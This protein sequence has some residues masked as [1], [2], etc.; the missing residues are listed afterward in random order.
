[1]TALTHTHTHTQTQVFFNDQEHVI[2]VRKRPHLEAFMERVAQ[3]F[4]VVLFT[5]S[6][7]IYAEV[8]ACVRCACG[9]S[10]QK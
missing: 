10:G 3:M 4:E 1:M 5:A 6:Q 7:K 8:C 2:N 9:V